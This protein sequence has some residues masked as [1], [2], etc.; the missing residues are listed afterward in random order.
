MVPTVHLTIEVV[1]LL[2]TKIL[3]VCGPNYQ[4]PSAF[5]KSSKSARR[6]HFYR[7]ERTC[8][9]FDQPYFCSGVV[10]E[11]EICAQDPLNF[12]FISFLVIKTFLE[13]FN[14]LNYFAGM[15]LMMVGGS[16]LAH[17]TLSKDTSYNSFDQ[18]ILFFLFT[19][20]SIT[21][22]VM[23][24]HFGYKHKEFMRSLKI[25]EDVGKILHKLRLEPSI[26]PVRAVM[27]FFYSASSALGILY[28][29][30]LLYQ[31]RSII[32]IIF[33][34]MTTGTVLFVQ[35]I[36]LLYFVSTCFLII[37]NVAVVNKYLETF[38]E[39]ADFSQKT[40]KNLRTT[41]E[42]HFLLCEA[43]KHLVS[44]CDLTILIYGVRA[45]VMVFLWI[46]SLNGM[47]P[48]MIIDTIGNLMCYT[49]AIIIIITMSEILKSEVYLH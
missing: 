17:V 28:Y 33:S 30:I 45:Q 3:T 32:F 13:R 43:L 27:I 35:H 4:L 40:E 21:G 16:F 47:L 31:G 26:K 20:P 23:L 14:I 49:I 38:E 42:V 6:Y 18:A 36:I 41:A 48:K 34:Y 46:L 22:T 15:V 1:L 29:S 10:D 7:K 9:T 12:A 5:V 44:A 25:L 8:R 19:E 24:I 11:L 37:H 39:Q 2:Y